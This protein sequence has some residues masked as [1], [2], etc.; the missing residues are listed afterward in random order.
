MVTLKFLFCET[1][2]QKSISILKMKGLNILFVLFLVNVFSFAQEKLA[3]PQ[4]LL[5]N[6]FK[7]LI[8]TNTSNENGNTTIACRLIT[9]QLLDYGFSG[10]DINILALD[11]TKGNLIVRFK[12]SDKN[13]PLLLLAHLDVVDAN[14]G[15]WKFD[16]FKLTE[17]DGFYYGRGTTDDKAMAAIFIANLIRLKNE[18]F[19][20]DRDIVVCLTSD[21]ENAGPNG[22]QWLLREHRNLIDAE[23]CITEGG[24]G[25]IIN[26]RNTLNE[27]QVAEK[28]Y[29]SYRLTA[30][31]DGGHSSLPTKNNAIVQLSE[32]INN[33]SKYEFPV[34]L[35]VATRGYFEVMSKLLSGQS[36]KDMEAVIKENP[37][38]DALV[39]LTQTPYYNALLRT[40]CVATQVEGGQAENVLPTKAT[41]VINCRILPDTPEDTI[42]NTIKKVIANEK[43]QITPLWEYVSAKPSPLFPELANKI[44]KITKELWP[45]VRIIPTMET[46]ATDGLFLRNAGIPTYGVSGLFMD[47]NDLRA[48]GNDERIA[49][50][51]LFESQE[52]LYQ[53]VKEICVTNQ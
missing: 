53:L 22:I 45:S 46:G 51:S 21:E 1:I 37:N 40:T 4:I 38:E 17:S 8:E 11:S 16:P 49:L 24:I 33:L 50:K 2:N 15:D 42:L 44:T 32:A 3:E 20:P 25:E 12:G 23:Y 29:Q 43:I 34:K 28:I 5:Q 26:G 6:I 14:K 9:K 19:A 52:F 7:D 10:K 48:H 18:R 39:R 27:I 13:K 31:G 30:V 41:S 35:N 36:A 47:I